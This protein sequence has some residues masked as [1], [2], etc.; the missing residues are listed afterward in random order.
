[1]G[2]N[3]T[4]IKLVGFPRVLLVNRRSVQLSVISSRLVKSKNLVQHNIWHACSLLAPILVGFLLAC[5]LESTVLR[6]EQ[7]HLTSNI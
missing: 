6:F 4:S 3:K 7:F 2:R 5:L 1:M